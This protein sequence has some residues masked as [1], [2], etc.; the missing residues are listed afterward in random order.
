MSGLRLSRSIPALILLAALSMTLT[1]YTVG[2]AQDAGHDEPSPSPIELGVTAADR[3]AAATAQVHYHITPARTDAGAA[4][5]LN[6]PDSLAIAK[7][8]AQRAAASLSRRIGAVPSPGFYPANLAYSSGKTIQSTVMH[9]VYLGCADGSCW[10]N[11]LGFEKDLVK[12]RF[13]HLIDQYVG[14][15][16]DQRYAVGA[17]MPM[18]AVASNC[19]S[20]GLCTGGDII[21]IALA[22]SA[23]GGAG[24]GHLYHIFLPQGVDTCAKA[25]DAIHPTNRMNSRS[26]ATTARRSP[27]ARPP[28]SPWSPTRMSPAARS[29]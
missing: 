22:A 29:P 3:D 2:V 12:S 5:A 10:G 1:S 20:A 9:N 18:G 16:A 8:A 13:I 19:S 24:G 17:E 21:A 6:G 15:M 23:A 4:A 27:A 28:T 14:S 11:P 25:S 7:L 26:A